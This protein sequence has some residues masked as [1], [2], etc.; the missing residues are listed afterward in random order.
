MLFSR[1]RGA[2]CFPDNASSQKLQNESWEVPR[3]PT[4]SIARR[5]PKTSQSHWSTCQGL[6]LKTRCSQCD[7]GRGVSKLMTCDSEKN[8][9]N[10][11]NTWV[12]KPLPLLSTS[13]RICSSSAGSFSMP[14]WQFHTAVMQ[15]RVQIKGQ[16]PGVVFYKNALANDG[17]DTNDQLN[18]TRPN[19]KCNSCLLHAFFKLLQV[20]HKK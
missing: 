11:N 18:T 4:I 6:Q 1:G 15:N 9:N 17:R 16:Q 3:L 2:F 20:T 13:L 14:A 12:L 10:R 8:G 5:N 7:L 19:K